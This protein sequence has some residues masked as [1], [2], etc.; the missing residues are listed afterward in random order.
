MTTRMFL[1][2]FYGILFLIPGLCLQAQ[3]HLHKDHSHKDQAADSRHKH[4]A[5]SANPLVLLESSRTG[6]LLK[7]LG[8]DGKLQTLYRIPKGA[9]LFQ[10]DHAHGDATTGKAEML[11]AYGPQGKGEQGIWRF[12][13]V[14]R[15]AQK[16]TVR[17]TPVIT[18]SDPNNW[19]FDPIYVPGTRNFYYISAKTK[20][21]S[22]RATQDL[23][24][25]FYDAEKKRSVAV[26]KDASHPTM[27]ETGEQLMW[28]NQ[29]KASQ[30]LTVLYHQNQKTRQIQLT[31]KLPSVH[32]PKISQALQAI[33]FLT[34]EKPTTVALPGFPQA[35]AHPGQQHKTWY[36]WQSPLDVSEIEQARLL[37]QA[38]NVRDLQLH[39]NGKQLGYLTEKGLTLYT[40]ENQTIDRI[41]SGPNF[42]KFI[43]IA[44]H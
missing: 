16:A 27:S 17:L 40:P 25:W 32:F 4:E 37:W 22:N 18:D 23:Q 33:F 30:S 42:W 29:H 35:F 43:W 14:L 12:E 34:T 9:R 15:P 1:Y 26:A 36:A 8:S 6:P 7:Y 13:Y 2:V 44:G 38:E 24:L 28:L 5:G 20:R 10:F 11:L 3:A 19:F 21:N 41:I 31:E 39:P